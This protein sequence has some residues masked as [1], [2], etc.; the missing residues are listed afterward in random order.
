MINFYRNMILIVLCVLFS[1][2]LSAANKK[3]NYYRTFWLPV[4][5][6]QRLAYC[7]MDS[8]TCGMAMATRYCQLMG[9]EKADHEIMDH[10][11]GLTNYLGS[12]DRC[13]GWRCNGFKTIRCV[14]NV[15]RNPPQSYHYQLRRFVYPRFNHYRVDWCYDGEAGCGRKAAHSFCRRMGYLKAR[16]YS[17]EREIYATKAIGNQKLCFGKECNAFREIDCYR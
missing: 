17:I 12:P 8:K 14:G 16:H 5:H 10:N 9:Y 4:Y 3:E 2:I 15:S 1:G 11:V 7:S 13:V 6:G